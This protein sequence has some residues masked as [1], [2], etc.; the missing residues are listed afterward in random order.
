MIFGQVINGRGKIADLGRHKQGKSF[1]K[2][3]AQPPIFSGS[4]VV[5]AVCL[6]VCFVL[7]LLA[8]LFFPSFL[9]PNLSSL[10]ACVLVFSFPF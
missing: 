9:S 8:C 2:R 7:S 1:G 6:F 5:P 10:L 3:P 4:S